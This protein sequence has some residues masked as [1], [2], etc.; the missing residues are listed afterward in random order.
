M[1]CNFL[2]GDVIDGTAGGS[3]KKGTQK[4]T[5][6][7]TQKGT[8]PKAWVGASLSALER[9]NNTTSW[10]GRDEALPYTA[11]K[12]RWSQQRHQWTQQRL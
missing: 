5:Q 11:A 4:E 3:V 6:S 8:H 1:R 10:R 7:V 2:A 12:P 9:V